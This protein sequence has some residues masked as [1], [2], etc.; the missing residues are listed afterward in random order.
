MTELKQKTEILDCTY[1]IKRL[2]VMQECSTKR[3]G[4]KRRKK[5]IYIFM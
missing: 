1:R 3:R 5:Y 2:S 4:G